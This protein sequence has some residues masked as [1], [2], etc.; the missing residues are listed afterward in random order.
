MN[1][2]AL[3]WAWRH[4]LMRDRVDVRWPWRE[5]ARKRD[6]EGEGQTEHELIGA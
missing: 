6:A 5:I 3:K 1:E 2:I 4:G